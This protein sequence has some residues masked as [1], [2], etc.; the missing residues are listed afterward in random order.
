MGAIDAHATVRA[1]ECARAYSC[2]CVA[3]LL[4]FIVVVGLLDCVVFVFVLCSLLQPVLQSILYVY[5]HFLSCFSFRFVFFF[6]LKSIFH[7]LRIYMNFFF[8]GQL[9]YMQCATFLMP[10][11]H[12]HR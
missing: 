12:T 10:H 1:C 11:I 7:T 5:A 2:A 9:T 4:V 3:L 8:F 6:V